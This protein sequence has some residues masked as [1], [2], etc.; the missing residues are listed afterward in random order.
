MLYAGITAHAIAQSHVRDPI[1]IAFATEA[2]CPDHE[3]TR[4]GN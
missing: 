3:A 1:P 4:L 2:R